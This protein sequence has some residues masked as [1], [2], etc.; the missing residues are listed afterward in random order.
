[1]TCFD[2][3]DFSQLVD[4]A[5]IYEEGLK[6]SSTA[7]TKHKKRNFIP[8]A[9]SFGGVGINKRM[10]IGGHQFQR[11]PLDCAPVAPQYPPQQNQQSQQTQNGQALALCRQC[12]R[13]HWGACRV[14]SGTCF[15]CGQFGHFNKEC[16]AK[17]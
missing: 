13:V 7:A 6:G 1:M 15:K 12:N 8:K 14:G 5:S 4:R 3:R 10:A 2:I 16:T 17:M 11:P 9:T